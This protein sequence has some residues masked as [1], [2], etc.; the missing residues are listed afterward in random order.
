[1]AIDTSGDRPGN[2]IADIPHGASAPGGALT[3]RPREI[4]KTYSGLNSLL[5][6]RGEAAAGVHFIH[7]DGTSYAGGRRKGADEPYAADKWTE[8][9]D[10]A[11][12]TDD[13]VR[14][15]LMEIGRVNLLTKKQ[16]QTLAREIEEWKHLEAIETELEALT[17]GSL[18][19]WM[20]V[21]HLMRRIGQLGPIVNAVCRYHAMRI[22]ET[23]TDVL[24]DE[25]LSEC[26]DGVLPEEML[27][28]AAE[29]LDGE[30]EDVK[31]G[32]IELSLAIRLLPMEAAAVFATSPA[33]RELQDLELAPGFIEALKSYDPVYW[34][35][36]ASVRNAGR[37]A[38]LHLSEANLR[39][40][41]SIAKKYLDRG[42]PLS[43]LIQEGNI[44]LIRGVQKF[45]YRRGYKFST[46]ATWWIRQAMSRSI[47]DQSRTIRV[48]VH[49]TEV[50][51]KLMRAT[52]KFVQEYGRDPT[53]EETGARMD[54]TAERVREIRKLTQLPLA[55][56][57]PVG[58]DGGAQ[59]G[60]FI[61][62]RD[63]VPPVEAMSYLLLREQ[64]ADALAT[65]SER[66]ARV[67]ELRF[68]IGDGIS[69]TLEQ[70]G[71]EFGVT[72]ERIR[73]IEAKAL[74]KLRQ[75]NHSRKLRDFLD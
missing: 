12:I 59:L 58:E 17:D 38:Q 5:P 69:H 30:P 53:D 41:V 32:L 24:N 3:R 22:S 23:L 42:M 43:D 63:Q 74:K 20:C 21:L 47:A 70:V 50:V 33:I 73:Q 62:D 40:V 25:E 16:E 54:I 2:V 35:H 6:G 65:L 61:E 14:L 39:L 10:L 4:V 71:Q 27:L 26:I 34:R 72:R 60:D 67:L 55:L 28:F 46:Y 13:S 45:D 49:M 1:M 18:S 57:T 51:N 9:I 19:A 56:E 48:P 66:E 11:D 29:I 8:S 36:F 44:G 37:R 52:R 7:Y 68:G 75:P 31:Q 15:Y 64:I